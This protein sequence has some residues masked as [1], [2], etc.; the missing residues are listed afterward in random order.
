[1]AHS[2]IMEGAMVEEVVVFIK[3]GTPADSMDGR[4]TTHL[5]YS[6]E[7]QV[8]YLKVLPLLFLVILVHSN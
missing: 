5:T 7:V 6:V 4:T 8:R 2:A 1:M 3:I